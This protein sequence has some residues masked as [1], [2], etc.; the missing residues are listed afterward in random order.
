MFVKYSRDLEKKATSAAFYKIKKVL[1]TFGH[2]TIS[3]I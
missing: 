2:I 3:A 1:I